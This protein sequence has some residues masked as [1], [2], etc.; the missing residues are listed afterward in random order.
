MAPEP[1]S[2]RGFL[3]AGGGLV[4]AA[5]T[6]GRVGAIPAKKVPLSP[7]VLSTDLYASPTPQR[8]AVAI[9]QGTHYA[10][11]GSLQ[12]ALQPPGSKQGSVYD[13]TLHK[14][15]LPKGRGI[16]VAQAVLPQAGVWNALALKNGKRV[17]FA[18]QVKPQP[19]AIAVGAP[20]P[21]APSPTPQNTLGVKPIC[22]RVPQC[23]LHNVSLSDVIGTGKPVAALFATP[24]LCQSMY[25]GPVLDELLKIKAAYEPKVT[26]VHV[27]IYTSTSGATVA[28]TVAAWGLPGEPW[29]YTINGG[30]T[31]VG[32]T[33]GAFGGDEMKAQLDALI[34]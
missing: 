15:G 34:A 25:C 4:L 3:V 33:D 12:V 14:A 30:G 18:I 7:L 32:R 23:P 9:A 16:F 27:E 22:T 5:A 20:A 24:A 17:P 6:A 29:L 2:R 21:R 11:F 10:S 31:V 26:F 28:P 13:T 1:L 19:E 8:L